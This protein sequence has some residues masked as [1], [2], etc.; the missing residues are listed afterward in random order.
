MSVAYIDFY[1][2][3]SSGEVRQLLPQRVYA[4]GRGDDV[5][6][7]IQDTLTSRRHCELRWDDQAFWTLVDLKSRNGTYVNG[8]KLTEKPILVSDHDV[9]QVGGQQFTYHMLPP[10]SDVASL[11]KKE[12]AA[13]IKSLETFEVQASDISGG[14]SGPSFTGQLRDQGLKELLRFFN[15]TKKTGRLMLANSM[16]KQ[17]WIV[18]GVPR[19]AMSGATRGLDAVKALMALGDGA[20]A[21][22]EGEQ[23]EKWSIEGDSTGILKQLIGA[24]DLDDL[25][26]DSADLAKAEI[27]QRHML[28]RIPK[29]PGYDLGV[30]F[31]GRS[32][33]SG[34]VYDVGLMPDGKL[35]VVLGDVAGH[36]VQAAMVVTSMLKSLRTLRRKTNDFVEL[37]ANLNDEIKE[38]LLPGQFLTMFAAVLTPWNGDLTVALCGHHP[39]YLFRRDGTRPPQSLGMPGMALGI[40]SGKTFRTKLKPVTV[41]LHPGDAIVQY[42]DGLL[43]AMDKDNQEFGD[44]RVRD[45]L[46]RHA[47]LEKVQ[48]IADAIAA[49]VTRFAAKLEDDLTVLC[50][51]RTDEAPAPKPAG[52]DSGAVPLG[53]TANISPEEARK[54]RASVDPA[55]AKASG[56]KIEAV[57][58][59]PPPRRVD[60]DTIN[61]RSAAAS[62]GFDLAASVAA[63]DVDL[64]ATAKAIVAAQLA[65]RGQP[66]SAQPPGAQPPSGTR[67]SVEKPRD[68]TAPMD[69]S[70]GWVGRKLGQV[71]LVCRIGGGA[72]GAVYRGHHEV[73]DTDVAVKVMLPKA[74]A[75]QDEHARKRFLQ[76][77]RTAA[78]I[79]HANV[80]QV[81]DAGATDDGATYLIMELIEGMGLGRRLEDHGKM[82]VDEVVAIAKGCAEGLA[83]IHAQGVVHRDIK[84]DN[85]LLDLRG[86]PKISDLGMARSVDDTDAQRLTMTG[87]II[88]TPAY[89]SPEAIEDSRQ[90]G[91]KSDVYSLGVTFYHLLAGRPPYTG[92]TAYQVMMAHMEGKYE[93]LRKLVQ[94]L[95]KDLGEIIESCFAKDPEHR[96]SAAQLGEML[97]L[98]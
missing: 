40:T 38:D 66:P 84:P 56:S 85:I 98:S 33:I 89:I 35:L 49:D 25:G 10:G 88:G 76:E 69:A 34:D 80:L 94:D 45:G 1:L 13:S 79:R 81:L 42:T 39:G 24:N 72:M 27:M 96:P 57:G 71:Q 86:V 97:G 77:A 46:T 95:P 52:I 53:E 31:Q 83:A 20:F 62:E 44:E 30:F 28:A 41:Q 14:T 61:A 5:D 60:E 3:A 54:L 74:D 55:I 75:R 6:F 9:V 91:P 18:E 8:R 70:D 12:G 29:V 37:L 90:A 2:V 92:S 68:P 51:G 78:R 11:T 32:G 4:F 7:Q 15:L 73:L 23:P 67:P 93:P 65:P 59:R 16:V 26:I 63:V 47:N 64:A 82:S 50:I 22:H 48:A 21:F 17:C 87:I 43:E 58:G 19:H 36:G